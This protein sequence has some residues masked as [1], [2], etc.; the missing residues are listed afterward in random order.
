MIIKSKFIKDYIQL[1]D[2]IPFMITISHIDAKLPC[3]A[4][5]FSVPSLNN[6]SLTFKELEKRVSLVYP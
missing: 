6:Y 4:K 3:D 1:Y 2:S 5:D